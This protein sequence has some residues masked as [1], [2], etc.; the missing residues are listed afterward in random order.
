[1]VF[2]STSQV[3]QQIGE[4]DGKVILEPL[5]PPSR[6]NHT[7]SSISGKGDQLDKQQFSVPSYV[8]HTKS[9]SSGSQSSVKP[10]PR[11]LP[12]QSKNDSFEDFHEFVN[13]VD[14]T[15]SEALSDYCNI[16][17]MTRVH[18]PT[19]T[20]FTSNLDGNKSWVIKPYPRKGSGAM[21]SIREWKI[22]PEEDQD[23]PSCATIHTDPAIIFS[24]G[25]YSGNLFHDFSDIIIPLVTNTQAFNRK[26]HL[27]VTNNKSWWIYKFQTLLNHLSNYQVV[28]IDIENQIHCYPNTII[29]LKSYK[30]LAID[31]SRSINNYS[32]NNFR[33]F[34]RSTYSL[35]RREVIN[36]KSNNNQRPRLM[37][38]SRKSTRRI[39]NEAKIVRM[40]QK[41]GY[42]V[43]IANETLIT[44]LSKF[45][46]IVNSCDVFMGVHGAGLTNMVFLPDHAVVIQVVPLGGIE[47]IARM[48]FEEPS[49]DMKLR[50]LKYS[51]RVKESS[52]STQYAADDV[53][54]R[55]PIVIHK[56]G[57]DVLR[58][59]YLVQ[60]N[61]KLDVRRFRSTLLKAL[62]LLQTF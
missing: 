52:L 18:G 49:K 29:G 4:K 3:E 21:K 14:C 6:D 27:L 55:D 9:I 13:S 37:I 60:Q 53:V 19:S 51:I 44:N 62:K 28:N 46:Q 23:M 42:E 15:L 34:L 25:G 10:T 7:K 22:K 31:S 35:E 54:L 32:M 33:D 5:N 20:I 38:I 26:V 59:T 57:W 16:K 2:L 47:G 41:L 11:I 1:M 40:A 12:S 39:T 36:L 50:Y 45:S 8:N 24:I 61:V 56:Q 43:I 48:D 17:G 58:N 30:E